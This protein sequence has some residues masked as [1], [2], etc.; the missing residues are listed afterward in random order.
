MSAPD[1]DVQVPLW[2]FFAILMLAVVATACA[3]VMYVGYSCVAE[4]TEMHARD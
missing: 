2:V 3:T 4:L 1:D